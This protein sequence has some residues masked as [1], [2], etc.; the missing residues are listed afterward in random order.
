MKKALRS[1]F[2]EEMKNF[3]MQKTGIPVPADFLPCPLPEDIFRCSM[4]KQKRYYHYYQN[5]TMI[6]S[7]QETG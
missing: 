4:S 2:T 3:R 1:S 6:Y 7:L 5:L